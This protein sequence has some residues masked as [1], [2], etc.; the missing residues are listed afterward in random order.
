MNTTRYTVT[1]Y[2]Q[3]LMPPE[4]IMNLQTGFQRTQQ[5]IHEKSFLPL[6]IKKY[7]GNTFTSRLFDNPNQ[8]MSITG[9]KGRGLG[10]ERLNKG[11]VFLLVAGTGLFPFLDLLDVLFK[12]VVGGVV[13]M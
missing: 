11:K 2:G 4:T 7:S 1:H 9:L 3:S 6:L 8:N 12:L 10:I 13:R 5:Y